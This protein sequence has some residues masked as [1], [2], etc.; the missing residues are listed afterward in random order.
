MTK[1]SPYF[2]SPSKLTASSEIAASSLRCSDLSI[3]HYKRDQIGLGLTNPNPIAPMIMAV[4]I[5]R[6]LPTHA[7]WR[8]GKPVTVPH[9]HAGSLSCLDFRQTWT[10]DLPHPFETFH[11]FLPLECVEEI[12]DGSK[13]RWIGSLDCSNAEAR[14][15]TVMHSLACAMLPALSGTRS[16]SPLFADHVCLAMVTH[17]AKLMEHSDQYLRGGAWLLVRSSGRKRF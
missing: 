3:A 12:S 11:A 14:L 2:A 5:L 10:S 4:V 9:M 17:L 1:S 8:D 15:D 6:D 7:G 16:A 13:R